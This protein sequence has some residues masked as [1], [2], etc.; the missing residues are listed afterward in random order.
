M[1]A[2]TKA[3][4]A[5]LER[6]HNGAVA[7]K[8]SK[9]QKLRRLV[10]ATMLWEDNFYVDGVSQAEYIK[11][12]L[13]EA[14]PEEVA[15]LAIEARESAKLRHLPLFLVRELARHPNKEARKLVS[16]T[17]ERIIQR[18]DEIT[19]FVAIYWKDGKQPLSAQ[20]KKGLAAAFNKFNEYSF[21]KFQKADSAI[22]LRDALFLTHAT[23]KNES[24]AEIF[25]KITDQ[26]LEIPDTWEVS[27]S[28]GADK[29]DTFTRLIDEGKLGALAL[30][31]NLRNMEQAGVSSGV[32]KSALV[33]MN[34]ER[35]LPFR[36]ISAARHA[37][38]YEPQLEQAMFK[39]LNGHDKLSGKT[40]LLVDVSGSMNYSVSAKSDLNR[41]D[42]ACGLAMLLREVCEDVEIATFNY[43]VE[44]VPARRGFALRDAIGGPRG[45]TDIGKAVDFAN[46]R[47]YNRLIV[48][49]D[50]QSDTLVGKPL[51]GTKG[52]MINVANYKNGIGSGVWNRI[53]GWS[54]AVVDYI[55]ES[56][57]D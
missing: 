46:K 19:E 2:N 26:T 52:Y 40:M 18:P 4:A 45:G 51:P 14:T 56:E 54:E 9:S 44:P 31:R 30:L 32:I 57:K 37:A 48:I 11:E 22:K 17:L 25:K 16:S 1:R 41:L 28:G 33:N 23:P 34:T 35:V 20:V 15:A 10:L 43:N 53:D 38:Q 8:L 5:V 47:G 6:T 24:Q 12:A 36:F 7:A 55:V 42:A 50:E 49:T 29:K 27:L 39:C 13:L 21:A 3:P